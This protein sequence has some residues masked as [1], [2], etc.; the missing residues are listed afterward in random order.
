MIKRPR[1]PTQFEHLSNELIYEIFD[2]FETIFLFETFSTLNQRFSSLIPPK[3]SFHLMK[4]RSF[5][6]FYSKFFV[7]HRS[8]FVSLNVE[9]FSLMNFSFDD[10]FSSLENLRLCQIP[11]RRF[12]SLFVELERLKS[13]NSFVFQT[14]NYF[15]DVNSIFSSIFRLKTLKFCR[16][17]FASANSIV[18]FGFDEKSN[19]EH[20]IIDG[21]F[22]LDQLVVVLKSTPKLRRFSSTNFF[23]SN[24]DVEKISSFNVELKTIELI[25]NRVDIDEIR[26]FLQNVGQ[27]IETLRIRSKNEDETFSTEFWRNFAEKSLPKLVK[28]DFEPFR[29]ETQ[30]LTID[31]E[32]QLFRNEKIVELHLTSSTISREEIFRLLQNFPNVRKLNLSTENFFVSNDNEFRRFSSKIVDLSLNDVLPCRPSNL[33]SILRDFPQ[34]ETLEISIEPKSSSKIVEILLSFPRL[35]FVSFVNLSIEKFVTSKKFHIEEN[36]GGFSIWW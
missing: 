28:L 7:V 4:K 15:S 5:D 21:P 1:R 22:R 32:I 14:S 29:S 25:F 9:N 36:R 16:L 12:S 31:G 11:F 2:Y 6:E 26:I 20:L 23:A 24:G 33:R 17:T 30:C 8:K 10:V 18:P 34:L 3:I 19:L 27:T 35:F 13:L